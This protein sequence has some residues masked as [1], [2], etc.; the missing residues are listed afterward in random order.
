MAR[1]LEMDALKR[2]RRPRASPLGVPVGTTRENGIFPNLRDAGKWSRDARRSELLPGAI[3]I[4]KLVIYYKSSLT[5][6]RPV[7]ILIELSAQALIMRSL[8]S[9][10]R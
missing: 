2:A 4:G 3:Q 8:E 1:A 10:D 6:L 9:D 7:Y 5:Y